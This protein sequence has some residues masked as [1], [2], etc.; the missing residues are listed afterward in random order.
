[1]FQVSW[2]RRKKKRKKW[3]T[4]NASFGSGT[5]ADLEDVRDDWYDENGD[6]IDEDDDEEGNS[7]QVKTEM[8]GG[9]NTNQDIDLSDE[10]VSETAESLEEALKNLANTHG[11]ENVYLE[12]PELDIDELIIDNKVIHALCET[13][14]SDIPKNDLEYGPDFFIQK[15]P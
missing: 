12:L 14:A 9:S 13:A 4:E 10:I 15:V 6:L 2:R 5:G 1:M 3:K 7:P 8:G 11:R